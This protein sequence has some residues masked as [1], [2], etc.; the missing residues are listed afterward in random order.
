LAV[1]IGAEYITSPDQ[2]KKKNRENQAKSEDLFFWSDRQDVFRTVAKGTHEE[3]IEIRNT[4]GSLLLA[5][6][7]T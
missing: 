6:H 5:I 3:P 7:L 2:W 4:N 1:V